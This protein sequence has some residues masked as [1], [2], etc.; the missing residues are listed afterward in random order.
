MIR[1]EK[2]HRVLAVGVVVSKDGSSLVN[3]AEFGASDNPQ[4]YHTTVFGR[5]L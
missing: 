1:T 3:D 5:L 2:A 4:I